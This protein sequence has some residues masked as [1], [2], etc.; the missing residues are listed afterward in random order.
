[1]LLCNVARL[2]VFLEFRERLLLIKGVNALI[3]GLGASHGVLTLLGR[4]RIVIPLIEA[5]RNQGFL[6]WENFLLRSNNTNKL[7]L[8]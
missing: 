4:K 8:H 5:W 7:N 2:F 1:M 6:T 3:P